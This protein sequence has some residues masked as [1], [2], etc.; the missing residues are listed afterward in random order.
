MKMKT[1]LLLGVIGAVVFAVANAK[2]IERYL[3]LRGM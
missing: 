2:D 1:L 3:K